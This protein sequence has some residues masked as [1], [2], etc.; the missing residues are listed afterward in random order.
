MCTVMQL[1]SDRVLRHAEHKKTFLQAA[2]WLISG[3]AARAVAVAGQGEA[4]REST[5]VSTTVQGS[6]S[7]A[8]SMLV[9][10]AVMAATVWQHEKRCV[11]SEACHRRG[12]MLSS[13]SSSCCALCFA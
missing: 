12:S 11:C 2:M 10:T 7:F 8:I 4:P 13:S 6:L 3:N 5:D 9:C 1:C